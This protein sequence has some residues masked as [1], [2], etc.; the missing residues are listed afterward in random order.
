M[1]EEAK[2]TQTNYDA[3]DIL[4][5][6]GGGGP[7]WKFDQPGDRDTGTILHPPQARQERE[8]VKDNPGGG[9]GKVFPSGDPIMGVL[10]D[11]QTSRRDDTDDDGQRTFYIEGKRLKMAVRDAVREAGAS[12]LEVGGVLDVTLTHYDIAGDRKSGR[13]WKIIYTPAGNAALM[14][15]TP[16][17]PPAAAAP[18]PAAAPTVTPEQAAAFAAWQASQNK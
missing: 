4:M 7:A 9:A 10:V 11:V 6:G 17:A 15:T 14:D 2:M 8:F 5:G 1:K 3:N 16:A 12:G 13:N 18:A